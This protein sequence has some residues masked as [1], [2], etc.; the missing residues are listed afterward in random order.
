MYPFLDP[1]GR[2]SP[3]KTATFALLFVPA[4]LVAA[5][6][7]AGNLGGRPF[8][9]ALRAIGL[10]NIRILFLSLAITPLAQV[11]RWRGLIQ[12]RRM[13][14]VAAAA[15]VLAHL[16]L[17]LGEEKFDFGRVAAEIVL[18][19][20]LAIGFVALLGLAALAATSTDAMARRLGGRNWRRL[21]RAAYGIGLL[22]LI[23]FFMQ[24]K[25]D[26]WEPLAMAGLLG[27]LLGYRVLAWRF[28][29]SGWRPLA[30]AAVG[31][32]AAPLMVALGE[33]VYF[34]LKMGAPPIDVLETNLSFDLGLRPAQLALAICGG[35][36]LLA[37]L[38]ALSSA[39]SA[40]RASAPA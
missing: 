25:A 32:V 13:V 17:Y 21:H 39:F 14:G 3:L 12:I 11:L 29:A 24:S 5:D 40:R 18:R 4:A 33:A 30:W 23:H 26:Q 22:G 28:G 16:A 7:I 6:W 19:I 9:E 20:Y 27:W 31:A 1:R 10:W 2:F 38:R 34:W 37:A 36:T 15:Y 8:Q 35:V